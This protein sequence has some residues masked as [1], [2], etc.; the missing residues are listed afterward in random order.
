MERKEEEEKKKNI[1]NSKE[2][3]V[4]PETST[5]AIPFETQRLEE[6]VLQFEAVNGKKGI[7]EN[8]VDAAE[9][10]CIL[11]PVGL[12]L[13]QNRKGKLNEGMLYFQRREQVVCHCS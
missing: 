11:I 8:W 12:P 9:Q 5:E 13:T 6:I 4:Q 10:A 1:K 2:S 7:K 3:F